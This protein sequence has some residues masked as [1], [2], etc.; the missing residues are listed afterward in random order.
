MRLHRSS[1][2]RDQQSVSAA[3]VLANVAKSARAKPRLARRPG[4]PA[5]LTI[6]FAATAH[7]LGEPG[8]RRRRGTKSLEECVGVSDPFS[9]NT[10]S[11]RLSAVTGN[12][13]SNLSM[14]RSREVFR[15]L[16]SNLYEMQRPVLVAQRCCPKVMRSRVPF[17]FPLRLRSGSRLPPLPALLRIG[18]DEVTG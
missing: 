16:Q 2:R 10:A 4:A 5:A 1:D 7:R 12:G 8:I 15:R 18:R 3:R 13:I 9:L 6:T 17:A 11:N 14:T